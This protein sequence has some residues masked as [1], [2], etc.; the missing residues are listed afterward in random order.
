M[1]RSW[2]V[3]LCLIP[4]TLLVLG[5]LLFPTLNMVISSFQTDDG[6]FTLTHYQ[7]L[8]TDAYYL[9]SIS[10]SLKISLLSATVAI[11]IAVIGG[12]SISQLA[13][14]SNKWMTTISNMTSYFEGIPLAFS[15]IVLLGNN[16]LF[17]LLFNQL[18]LDVF[19]NFDLY[20]WVG[21][22]VVYI[23]FQIPFAIILLLPTYQAINNEWRYASNLLGGTGWT[24]WRKVGIPLLFPGVI[25][26]YTILIANAL[27]A[28]ATANALVGSTYN[29]MPI[30]IAS[31]I[32]GD[33]FLQPN[34]AS[35]F[36][37]LLAFIMI[38]ALWLNSKI[39]KKVR[40]DLR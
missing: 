28:F 39:M 32:S 6:R 5:F 30:Q 40:R 8:F 26:T 11:V 27:G 22:V 12:Y 4:L 37:V 25:G 31:L 7:E 24:F 38:A 13:E 14:R 9:Q 18:G 20:S 2:K 15:F 10:N 23:Y 3:W 1:K 17:T 19:G 36:G 21:L 29:L 35:A 34:L 16:G 33:V